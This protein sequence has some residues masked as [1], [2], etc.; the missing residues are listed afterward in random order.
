MNGVDLVYWTVGKG[1][2]ATATRAVVRIR[3]YGTERLPREGGCVVAVNHAAF[4]DVPILGTVCPR[5]IAFV[6]KTELFDYPGLGQ[7]IRAHGT[8][9]I[10]RGESDRDA[11]RRMRETVRDGGVLGLFVEGTRQH[12]GEPGEAKPGAAMVAIQEGVPV[13]PVAIHS[14]AAWKASRRSPVSLAWGEPMRF[15]DL[16]RGSKGYQ[17][18]TREIEAEIRR[19]WEWLGRMHEAGLPRDATPPRRENAPVAGVTDAPLLGAVAV[20]GFPN[21][22]KSTLVNR[23]TA[24]REA[25]VF[26]T[27]GVTRDRKDV[28]CEWAGKRFVLVDTGGVDIADDSP[29][30]KQVA[31]QARRAVEEA[32]LVVFVVDAKAGVTPGDE[33]VADILRRSGKPVLVVAN[34]IDDPSRDDEALEFHRLGLGDPLPISALHGYGTGDLLDLVVEGLPGEGP[35]EVDGDAIRVAVLGRPN[36]GKSSLVNAIVGEERVIVS[37][38]PG[39]TRDAIDTVLRRGDTTFVLVDTAGMRRRRRHRQ[40]IEYFSELRT[41]KAAERADVALVLV[42]ASEGLVDQDLAVADVART[43]GDATLVVLS[44]WDVAAVGIEDVRPRIE[45]RLRQRPPVAAVSATTG[46]GVGKVL[47]RVE[48]LFAKHTARVS[49]AELNRILQELRETRPGPNKHGRRLNLLY[50]TQ[51]S[52]RPPRFRIFVNDPGLL[53]RDYGYWVENQLRD[54]LGLQGV[55]VIIDFVR[56]S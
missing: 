17:A 18:A 27:P 43:A 21:V 4:I 55:P 38:Q 47:D 53:T 26:E 14:S 51:V 11:L 48:E 41:I 33:E 35:P 28:V 42:D 31:E 16:P 34:K 24:T 54:R 50:G 7:L 5:R 3:S 9:A 6:A 40:G 20:V 37:D 45:K 22:G 32:D 44:K 52:T 49:T 46:R 29:L 2:L 15:A 39:T 19:L 8:I 23:L 1:I 25:V 13:V 12:S 10:R 36:V 30:T 56:R